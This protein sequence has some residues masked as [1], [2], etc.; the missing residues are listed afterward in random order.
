[1]SKYPVF[2]PSIFQLTHTDAKLF[3]HVSRLIYEQS[4]HD[5][6]QHLHISLRLTYS[7]LIHGIFYFQFRFVVVV[8]QNQL[9]GVVRKPVL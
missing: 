9:K 3:I 4:H 5:L 6:A 1:M 2:I 8:C 7:F